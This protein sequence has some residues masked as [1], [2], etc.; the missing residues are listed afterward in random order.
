V[1][2]EQDMK[3]AP[4]AVVTAG[5][6]DTFCEESVAYGHRLADSGVKV[7]ITRYPRLPHGYLTHGSLPRE[8]RSQLAHDATMDTLRKVRDLVRS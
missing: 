8:H 3:G 7:S 5:L 2:L 4:P 6:L 1:L